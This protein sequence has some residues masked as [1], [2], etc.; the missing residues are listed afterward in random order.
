MLAVEWQRYGIR[1]NSIAPG[2]IASGGLG[3]Y[4]KKYLETIKKMGVNNLAGRLGTNAEV[5]NPVI[6]LLSPGASYITGASLR[7]DAG[8]SI[9]LQQTPLVKPSKD[10]WISIDDRIEKSSK[11]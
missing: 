1:V 5:T 11:L 9:A 8:E 7:V 2:M 10:T 4:D 6:F 3:K